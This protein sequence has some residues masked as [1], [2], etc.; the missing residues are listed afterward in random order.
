MDGEPSKPEQTF[1]DTVEKIKNTSAG[2]KMDSS[3]NLKLFS[4]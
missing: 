4:E 1:D 2:A 3:L